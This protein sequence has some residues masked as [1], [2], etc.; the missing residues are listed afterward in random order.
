[1]KKTSVLI[2]DDHA[3]VRMGLAAIVNLEDD[4]E[5]CA[6][7]QSG[8]EAARLADEFK[9]D[10]A[11]CDMVMAGMDGAAATAAILAASPATRVLIL[12]TFGTSEEIARAIEAGAA[13]AVTKDIPHAELVQAIRD[14]ACGR[15]IISPQIRQ[16]LAAAE[17]PPNFTP[18]QREVLDSIT[19][20]LSN[21]DIAKMLGL[22]KGRIKQHL[23][24][25]YE[26]LGAAN[27]AEA[28]A[29][30]MRRHLLERLKG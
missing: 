19:R 3:V 8:E 7:A 2:V 29:I 28:V 26:K 4:L 27:R 6:Q 22:S 13:G 23:A 15:K 16:T 18:R 25:L 20:G 24:Q 12:T 21:D 14:T 11:V 10:V 5:V 1:M 30:A 9:P 17:P